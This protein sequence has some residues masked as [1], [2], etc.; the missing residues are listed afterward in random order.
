M[1]QDC[2]DSAAVSSHKEFPCYFLRKRH[3]CKEE[4]RMQTFRN[5]LCDQNCPT[6]QEMVDASFYYKRY[7]DRV[8]CIYYGGQLFKW[9]AYDNPWYEHAK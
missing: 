8:C 1:S 9:K 2:V 3:M 4:D 7:G 6:A 5:S